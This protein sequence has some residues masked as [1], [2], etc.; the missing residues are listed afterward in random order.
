MNYY[1]IIGVLVIAFGSWFIY[2]G[3][4][5]S[6]AKDKNDLIKQI[7]ITNKKIDELKDDKNIDVEKL[8]DIENEFAIWAEEFVSNKEKKKLDLQKKQIENQSNVLDLNSQWRPHFERFFSDI[9]SIIDAYN[10]TTKNKI[11]YDIKEL[12]K[13]IIDKKS[14]LFESFIYFKSDI[15]W[16]I[17]IRP[18]RNIAERKVPALGVEIFNE[19]P[20]DLTITIDQFSF[21][22]MEGDDYMLLVNISNTKTDLS[23]LHDKSVLS[24]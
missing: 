14:G 24:G 9:K 23:S 13:N 2:F 21:V 6:T 10:S 5:K 19:I 18:G 8:E 20:K 11:T 12:P 22:Y 4:N 16:K 3:I 17:S 15:I 1:I 7:N